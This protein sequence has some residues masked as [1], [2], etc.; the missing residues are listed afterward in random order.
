MRVTSPVLLFL[1]LTMASCH[2]TNPDRWEAE[3][4][5][6]RIHRGMTLKEILDAV[7]HTEASAVMVTHGGIQYDIILNPE[8]LISIRVARPAAGESPESSRINYSPSLR[9][10]RTGKRLSAKGEVW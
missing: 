8:Y 4:L 1:A 3:G 7:P 2:T 10:I 9:D 5:V 6:E